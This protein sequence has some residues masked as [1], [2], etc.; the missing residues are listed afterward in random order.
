MSQ[1]G[2][3][4]RT[5]SAVLPSLGD[6]AIILEPKHDVISE[7]E[8]DSKPR[9]VDDKEVIYIYIYIYIG[10]EGIRTDPTPRGVSCIGSIFKKILE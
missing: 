8:P 9:T 10:G 3:S 1:D 7:P 4:S 5:P 2:I 6:S